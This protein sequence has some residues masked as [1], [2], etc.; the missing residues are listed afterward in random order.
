VWY[1]NQFPGYPCTEILIRT[2][3]PLQNNRRQDVPL[4]QLL[5][6]SSSGLHVF[7]LPFPYSTAETV[8]S[9]P[10]RRSEENMYGGMNREFYWPRGGLPPRSPTRAPENDSKTPK[11]A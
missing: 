9:K 2:L 8:E 3:G 11:S 10:K 6:A 5:V 7:G 1:I 4:L